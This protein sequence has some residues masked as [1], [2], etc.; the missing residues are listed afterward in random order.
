MTK[1]RIKSGGH[2]NGVSAVGETRGGM[3]QLQRSGVAGNHV[4]Q[5]E[6]VSSAH[7][8][9][10]RRQFDVTDIFPTVTLCK[11][12]KNESISVNQRNVFRIQ[13]AL[14][15]IVQLVQRDKISRLVNS[16]E[17][18]IFPRP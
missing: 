2:I 14:V 5:F 17:A 10:T 6:F 1:D 7:R 16:I 18:K 8:S 12:H 13:N 3:E 4:G 9:A 11:K 15:P